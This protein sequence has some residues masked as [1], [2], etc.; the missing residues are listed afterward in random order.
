MRFCQ[1]MLLEILQ[2]SGCLVTKCCVHSIDI[3]GQTLLLLNSTDK[4]V[5]FDG[6]PLLKKGQKI[7]CHG[8][9]LVN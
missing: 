9:P 4:I 1:K 7:S 3:N 2:Q 6:Y 8:C 5:N